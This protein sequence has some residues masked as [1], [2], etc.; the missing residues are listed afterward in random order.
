MRKTLLLQ[1]ILVEL[2][3]Q[4]DPETNNLDHETKNQAAIEEI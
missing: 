4:N 3:I 1:F 2:V